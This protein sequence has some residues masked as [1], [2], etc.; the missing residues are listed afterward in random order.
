MTNRTKPG[1]GIGPT[2]EEVFERPWPLHPL[3]HA[4]RY[5]AQVHADDVRTGTTIPYLSHLLSVAALVM[6]DGGDETQVIA[7]L[8]HDA[9]EDDGGEE[10]L[11]DIEQRFGSQVADIV[12]ECS[13]SLRPEEVE[14]EDWAVRKGAY[15]AHLGDQPVPVLRVSLADK[16]H[17]A[18]C[19]LAD[20][21]QIGDGL[22][23]RFSGGRGGTL[24]Y[25]HD[26][27]E[28]FDRAA[29]RRSPYRSP[30]LGEL[31]RVLGDLD[32][33]VGSE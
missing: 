11:S 29:H 3:E 14:K 26:L 9:A 31:T 10:R 5:A 28:V 7:A 32:D 4:L 27:V 8:L 2:W 19:I 33:L 18:R 17:N 6:E 23:S 21:R 1:P 13:D 22:W 15:L 16:L 12:R 24:S 20:Y 25:S 30:M